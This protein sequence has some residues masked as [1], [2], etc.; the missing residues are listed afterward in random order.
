MRGELCIGFAS[1]LSFASVILLIFVHIGQINTS[2]VPRKISMVKVNMTGYGST[3]ETI[4]FPN[5]DTTSGLYTN[6]SSAPLNAQAGLRQFY[7]FGLYS[8]CGYVT[9]GEGI[10]GNHTA[11]QKYTPFDIIQSDMATNFSV[12]NA[13]IIP[14][15]TFRDSSYLGKS[16]KAAYWMILLG[17]I[18]AALALLTGVAKNNLTFFVSA[19]FSALGSLLLL[20]AASI[21]TVM[22][23]K[24]QVINTS[25]TPT[26]VPLN[27]IV[28]EG[29]GLFLTWAA[30]AC[31][32]VSVVPYVVSFKLRSLKVLVPLLFALIASTVQA[33]PKIT[34]S[35]RYLYDDS[36]S[37]FYI[38]GIA[39]QEQGDVV[40]SD[41]NPFG[42]PSSFVD[43]LSI[44]AACARDL[45]FL[46]ELGVNT[47]R[48]Y[49]VNSSLNH[50]ACM[51]A[52]S[53]A[54]IYAIIDLSIP[55]NGS[56]DRVSPSWSTNILDLYT[57]TIDTF[58]K[59]DNVLAFNVGNEVVIS[60]ATAV[61]PYIKAAARDIKAYLKSKSSS[62]L[63]GYSAINGASDW[64]GDLAD[65]L[66][67]DPSNSNSDSTAI[68]LYGLNDYE[69]CGDSTFQSSYAGTTSAFSDYNVV[70]YFSEF[71]CITSPPRLWTETVALFGSNMNTVWSGGI[72]FS[73]FPATSAQGQFGMVTISSDSKTVT[74]SDDFDRLKTEYN[75][76]SF[77]NSPSQSSAGSSTYP[78]CPAADSVFLASTTLP[79]TPNEAACNCLES[80]LSCQFTPSTTNYTA[81]VGE[82]LDFGCSLLGQEGSSACNDV[83]G[84]GSKG[85]YGRI[86]GCD[87]TIKLSYVMSQYYESQQRQTSACQFG[88]NG[89]VNSKTSS[90][91]T[92]DS[93]ASSCIANPG[94]VFT[95]SAAPTSK[96]PGP[97]G[98][99]KTGDNNTSGALSVV[100][101]SNALL[102]MSLMAFV[103]V[104]G[105]IWSLQ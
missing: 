5:T 3:I 58:S 8:Y 10:C 91:L 6:N 101:D 102:G 45:P 49:S 35:D 72:A 84:D 68:D 71:G 76:I 29:N 50:D 43:P 44:D 78:S 95:P 92:A 104:L 93:A 41:N 96:A 54:G 70:A 37:R 46:Q 85:V 67:C 39:Y 16:S 79:P 2:T 74:T 9:G 19:I 31:L 21:W 27:I 83:G 34:R 17:T 75:S 89:T 59:Y 86:S 56:I 105:G 87:P 77:I 82:L 15:N 12:L 100:G 62:A 80:A 22:I 40:A 1:I 98:T 60:N 90:S 88:G 13:A 66:S 4:T 32:I 53:Q 36:G 81:I 94:A 20:I 30:F 51:N 97:S 99:T 63:V 11:G 64:R 48:V 25:L 18:C 24:S 52:F 65:Y 47:I 7:D 33:I 103:S 69:W 14:E 38:K 55:L 26:N 42:E 23:K 61:S 73:Y 28:S 57:N